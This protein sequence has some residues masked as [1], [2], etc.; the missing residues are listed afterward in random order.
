MTSIRDK[1]DFNNSELARPAGQRTVPATRSNTRERDRTTNRLHV[2]IPWLLE[3]N[4]D[5]LL[6]VVGAFLLCAMVIAWL[7]FR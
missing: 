1:N 2:R 5:G 7:A 4:G 3:V 6:P